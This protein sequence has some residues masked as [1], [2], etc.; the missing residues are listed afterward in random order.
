[1]NQVTLQN[2]A[3]IKQSEMGSN[4][5]SALGRYQKGNTGA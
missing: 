1:M 2:N 4:R 5:N 3:A